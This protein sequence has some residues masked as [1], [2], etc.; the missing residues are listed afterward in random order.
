MAWYLNLSAN[1]RW[2]PSRGLSATEENDK[3]VSLLHCIWVP[4]HVTPA[5]TNL[6]FGSPLE[7]FAVKIFALI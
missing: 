7:E 4:S 3:N 2:I 1:M 6:A 5:A